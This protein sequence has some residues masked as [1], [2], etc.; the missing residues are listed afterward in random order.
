M[1]INV[2]VRQTR[3]LQNA[4]MSGAVKQEHRYTATVIGRRSPF[5]SLFELQHSAKRSFV[6]QTLY[7][8]KLLFYMPHL[9]WHRASQ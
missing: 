5:R 3:I 2:P 9:G 4:A 7:E 1:L 6:I 8:N